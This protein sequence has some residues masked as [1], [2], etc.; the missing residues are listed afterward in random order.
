MGAIH[1]SPLCV[2]TAQSAMRTSSTEICVPE[3]LMDAHPIPSRSHTTDK[4]PPLATQTQYDRHPS[5]VRS[6][7]PSARTTFPLNSPATSPHVPISEDF[8]FTTSKTCPLLVARNIRLIVRPR[9]C[10]CMLRISHQ[11][12]SMSMNNEVTGLEPW[13][14]PRVPSG[15]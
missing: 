1:C 4:H 6:T 11:V 2:R 3:A 14:C 10:I 8:V 7:R 12:R 13:F 15:C 5:P 9:A